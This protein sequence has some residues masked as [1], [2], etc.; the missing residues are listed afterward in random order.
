MLVPTPGL[1]L[2]SCPP[3]PPLP[4]LLLVGAFQ[5][6]S[7]YLRCLPAGWLRCCSHPPLP[8]FMPHLAALNPALSMEGLLTLPPA[9][10]LSSSLPWSAQSYALLEEGTEQHPPPPQTQSVGWGFSPE[11]KHGLWNPPLSLTDGGGSAVSL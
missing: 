7:L 6:S 2:L 8:V 9:Q 10:A 4:G 1:S 5:G 11:V 3:P